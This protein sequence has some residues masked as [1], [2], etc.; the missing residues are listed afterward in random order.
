MY[1]RSSA[2]DLEDVPL[3]EEDDGDSVEFQILAF[4]ARHHA[5]KGSPVPPARPRGPGPGAAD[6]W[7][8]VAGAWRSTPLGGKKPSWRRLFGGGPGRDEDPP[9]S[10]T[11][12]ESRAQDG[13][14]GQPSS[15]SLPGVERRGGSEAVGPK[16]ASIANR[17]AEIVYSWPPPEDRLHQGGSHK[18]EFAPQ[19]LRLQSFGT[20]EDE[21]DGEDPLIGRIVALLKASGDQLERELKKDKALLNGLRQALSYPVFKTITDRFLSTVDTRGESEGKV[22]GFKAALAIDAMAKLTA[23]DNHPMNRVLG[24]GA[25]Y[26]KDH[27]SPWVQQH[28]GW[29]KVLGLAHEEVD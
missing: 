17:V 3:E 9:G 7:T 25:K 2:C 20:E 11:C 19:C 6:S 21:R 14:H 24:F 29:E 13:A 8:Q 27:F 5:F 16:V 23:V 26:L 22:R 12:G 1:S 15:L 10:P 4:Y 18:F 28:G